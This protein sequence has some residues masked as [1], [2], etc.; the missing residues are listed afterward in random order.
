MWNLMQSLK[1]C[2]KC[3]VKCGLLTR[4]RFPNI[5]CCILPC[6][7]FQGEIHSIIAINRNKKLL[8]RPVDLETIARQNRAKCDVC[9]SVS[10]DYQIQHSCW[11]VILLLCIQG[12]LGSDFIWQ[13][14]ILYLVYLQPCQVLG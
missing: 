1:L 7:R 2:M 9:T 3:N 10:I 11:W 14:V 5:V 13:I 12:I 4:R 8:L 6:F